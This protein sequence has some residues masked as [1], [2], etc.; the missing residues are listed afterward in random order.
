MKPLLT[1]VVMALFAAGCS[2]PSGCS[3]PTTEPSCTRVEEALQAMPIRPRA[4]FR[5]KD[6]ESRYI[7]RLR[8]SIDGTL[9]ANRASVISEFAQCCAGDGGVRLVDKYGADRV[10]ALARR[11]FVVATEVRNASLAA[12]MIAIEANAGENLKY[13]AFLTAY[14]CASIDNGAAWTVEVLR[15]LV[16]QNAVAGTE[17]VRCMLD[18]GVSDSSPQD[19]LEKANGQVLEFDRAFIDE[20]GRGYLDLLGTRP[21]LRTRP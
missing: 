16:A 18:S 14:Y 17:V 11:G 1:L 15:E 8:A 13:I 19:L 21:L 4:G 20:V 9:E 2:N 7:D 12:N 10:V 6:E 5:T 3:G